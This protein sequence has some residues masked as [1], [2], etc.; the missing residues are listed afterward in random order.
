MRIDDHAVYA[1]LCLV[2]RQV[3]PQ[4]ARIDN[5]RHRLLFIDAVSPQIALIASGFYNLYQF[6]PAGVVQRFRDR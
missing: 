2:G 5:A 3:Y 4:S 1:S 6:P